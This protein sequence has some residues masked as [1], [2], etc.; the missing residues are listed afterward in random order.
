M[1]LEI[2]EVF[3]LWGADFCGGALLKGVVLADDGDRCV[4]IDLESSVFF[5][6]DLRN[7]CFCWIEGWW[8]K[9]LRNLELVAIFRVSEFAL[10]SGRCLWSR[11]LLIFLF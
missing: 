4:V 7:T 5:S 8:R 9:V 10:L 3:K 6:V 1:F 2:G 11:F